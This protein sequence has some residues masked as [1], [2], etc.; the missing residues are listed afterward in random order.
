[1][2]LGLLE[3]RNSA[4]AGDQFQTEPEQGTDTVPCKR[5]GDAILI[6]DQMYDWLRAL[7]K[8]HQLRQARDDVGKQVVN[9]FALSTF[10]GSG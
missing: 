7:S 6:K 3:Q 5:D 4:F 9:E 8:N 2:H 10:D 1:M